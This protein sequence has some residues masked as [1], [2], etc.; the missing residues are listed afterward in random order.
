MIDLL[1]R[2]A[3]PD[4][5]LRVEF[6]YPNYENDP[7]PDLL[8]LGNWVNPNTKN[9]LVGGIN[10][11]YLSSQQHH[12]LRDILPQLFDGR[13]RSLR[14]KYRALRNIA[15]DIAMYYRT[16]DARMMRHLDPSRLYV[17]GKAKSPEEVE[18]QKTKDELKQLKDKLRGAQPT[19][20][21]VEPKQ[22]VDTDK[23]AWRLKRQ[24]YS[25]DTKNKRNQP[26]RK[27]V[28][29]S[30][31]AVKAKANRY[32]SSRREL[33]ELERQAKIE[34]EL[35]KL[36]ADAADETDVIDVEPDVGQDVPEEGYVFDDTFGYICETP[37]SYIASHAP[38]RYNFTGG[39]LLAAYNVTTKQVIVDSAI[40]HAQ[41]L[42]EADWDFDDVVLFEVRDQEL[43][44]R[45]DNRHIH[46]GFDRLHKSGGM[47]LMVE[48]AK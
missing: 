31:A 38:R 25:P 3:R 21:P 13:R 32:R 15:P 7:R 20:K 43:S 23:K 27:N 5:Y 2:K 29:G 8:P 48:S 19:K 10:L 24:L 17:T 33:A 35:A 30:K 12:R 40:C 26:E 4:S 9:N 44:A 16:Y 42:A 39:G 1:E 18:K 46:D 34:R 14:S 6:D 41:M 45:G 47:Q 36:D 28:A 11:N 22:A 37:R